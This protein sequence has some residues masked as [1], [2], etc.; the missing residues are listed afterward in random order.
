MPRNS[1][2]CTVH[3]YSSVHMYSC[4][5]INFETPTQ[6]CQ[7]SGSIE[8]VDILILRTNEAI[9]ERCFISTR[10]NSRFINMKAK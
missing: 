4:T 7:D 10:L 3:L 2:L 8:I 9:A 5:S 1:F 6:A